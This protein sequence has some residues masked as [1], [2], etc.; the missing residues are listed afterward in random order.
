MSNDLP[1]E[2]I[3]NINEGNFC[4]PDYYVKKMMN[5][6]SISEQCMRCPPGKDEWYFQGPPE[7][8]PPNTRLTNTQL[9]QLKQCSGGSTVT[10]DFIRTLDPNFRET[11]ASGEPTW[12]SL[13]QSENVKHCPV[14]PIAGRVTDNET[15]QPDEIDAPNDEQ[16]TDTYE[17]QFKRFT[18]CVKTKIPKIEDEFTLVNE[19]KRISSNITEDCLDTLPP[20]DICEKGYSEL[21]TS[22]P[23][24]YLQENGIDQLTPPQQRVYDRTIRQLSR[25]A[26]ATE[27]NVCGTVTSQTASL[28]NIANQQLKDSFTDSPL[29]QGVSFVRS[30][31]R[32]VIYFL[33]YLLKT[34]GVWPQ[35]GASLHE[36]LI[37]ATRVVVFSLL[38]YI[39]MSMTR[40]MKPMSVS[41]M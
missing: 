13:Q 35:R 38:V 39:L 18:E 20:T 23:S 8:I 17:M 30:L 9:T 21:Y 28:N 31:M 37:I 2:V 34:I 15:C 1:P 14:D 26:Y 40:K 22:V 25:E 24:L 19:L 10:P 11:D 7:S 32:S 36:L 33:I 3:T 29:K 41:E 5:H 4:G 27:E 12:K 6:K 16:D